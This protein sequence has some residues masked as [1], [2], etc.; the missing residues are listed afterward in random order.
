MCYCDI[1]TPFENCCGQYL[2]GSKTPPTPVALMR[3]RYSAFVT[4]NIDFIDQTMRG[5]AR[6]DFDR[7]ENLNFCHVAQWVGLEVFNFDE[8]DNK[9]SVTFS[10]KYQINQDKYE[11]KEKSLFEKIDG[12]WFYVAGENIKEQTPKLG[13]NDP[14]Y[15]GSGRKF[16]K[17]CGA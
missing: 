2:D 7:D 6:E 8:K 13:R 10:A 5:S 15:C 9:G 16:K 12:Q 11:I 3:A 17:C 14:C 4:N 1:N